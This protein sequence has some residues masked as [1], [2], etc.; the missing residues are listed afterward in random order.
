M[1]DYMK[2]IIVL[3]LAIIIAFLTGC[4]SSQESIFGTFDVDFNTCQDTCS[5]D[6][7]T[8]SD[9]LSTYRDA[10]AAYELTIA[11][12]SNQESEFLVSQSNYTRLQIPVSD[13][14]TDNSG[15][16]ITLHNN[17][18]ALIFHYIEVV[19]HYVSEGGDN[20]SNPISSEL[21][22]I[23]NRNYGF[24]DLSGYYTHRSFLTSNASEATES[25]V[26]YSFNLN[27]EHIAFESIIYFPNSDRYQYMSYANNVYRGYSYFADDNYSFQYINTS[28]GHYISYNL[29]DDY[30]ITQ[31]YNPDTQMF[32]DKNRNF[33]HIAFY[34]DMQFVVSLDNMNEENFLEFSL[35]FMDGWDS[36]TYNDVSVS[37]YSIAYNNDQR[38][39]ADFDILTY[40]QSSN[41]YQVNIQKA[42]TTEE[43]STF[44]FPDEFVGDITF[45]Q[46]VQ[47]YE[48]LLD[49]DNILSMEDL[50]PDLIKEKCLEIL[51]LLSENYLD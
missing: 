24:D 49:N 5:T 43:L 39:Y 33:G 1:G 30:E 28:T 42:L 44:N 11:E 17:G 15:I 10:L 31:I 16:P 41:Y 32:Y 21:Y 22:Q 37:P 38:V 25:Y 6:L 4:T 51:S 3:L 29:T 7:Q 47:A 8:F 34:Q 40:R 36:L 20:Y 14:I 48:D 35:H 19:S 50:S 23:T 9:N 46:L 27:P 2:K 26:Y 45:D 12:N 13:P 18:F